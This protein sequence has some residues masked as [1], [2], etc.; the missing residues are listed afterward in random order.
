VDARPLSARNGAPP[1]ALGLW[2]EATFM[3]LSHRVASGG[4]F[5]WIL[6]GEGVRPK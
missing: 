1:G 6:G 4:P 5:G 2:G 3:A